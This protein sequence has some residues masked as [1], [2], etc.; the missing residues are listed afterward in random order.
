MRD[1]LPGAERAPC[2]KLVPE[3]RF[4]ELLRYVR[5]DDGDVARLA[6]FHRVAAPHFPAIAAE[7]YE[8][9]REHADAHAVLTGEE[10]IARLRGSLVKWM[11]RVCT[12]K[13]DDAY[14][15]ETSKIG[16]VHVKIGLPQR[17]VFTA[18][19]LI[20][21]AFGRIADRDLPGESKLM[22][23]T[24]VRALDLELAIM[25][26]AYQED[27]L[28]RMQRIERLERERA[29]A[30]SEHVYDKA[31]EL[32]PSIVV[33]VDAEGCIRVFNR[34]AER[35]TSFGRDEVMGRGFADVLLAEHVS[36]EIQSRL[37]AVIDGTREADELEAPLSTKAGHL[38]FVRWRLAHVPTDG[39]EEIAALA[40]G[41]DVTDQAA[42]AE[43]TRRAEKLAAVG[44]L[45]AGLA[46]EIRNPLNG[47]HLHVTFLERGMR[48]E[49]ASQDCIE[50]VRVVGDEIRRLSALVSEF[51]DFARP[52]PL[53]RRP[54]PLRGLCEHA[55]AL[56]A[57]DAAAAHT[58]VTLDL[59]VS[60]IVVSADP[61]KLEQVLLNLLRNAIE[62]MQPSGGGRVVLRVRRSPLVAVIEVEDE[63]PGVPTAGAPIFDAFYSTKSGGTGL[64]LPIVHR[65]VT[66]HG[67][68]VAYDSRPGRTVFHFTI[69]IEGVS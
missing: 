1:F 48:K 52:K 24:L 67:G 49:G 13:R 46:H 50:A 19:A 5:F 58:E 42:L 51:L 35:A 9:I 23:E 8:R 57:A 47:A 63:G 36:T 29:L 21:I 30:Q 66:D 17:F 3:S 65:I 22:H 31:I 43:R 2:A 27:T 40:V 25:I 34:A 38:R 39:A 18:M 68:T 4:Q 62:S 32:A 69:P 10:Q 54:V 14:F 56:L 28:A 44:T 37:R 53:D 33:G 12:G 61:S 64:G 60:D 11:E 7:F 41:D 26:D 45:A 59:P 6:A 15:E 55:V 16:R 20:G